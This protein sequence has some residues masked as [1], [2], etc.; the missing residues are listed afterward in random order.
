[1]L[2]VSL[3]GGWL[4]GSLKGFVL[5]L[6]YGWFCIEMSYNWSRVKNYSWASTA[7]SVY[8]KKILIIID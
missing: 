8:S 2:F 7:A 3:D 5:R 4:V 6:E 1:M